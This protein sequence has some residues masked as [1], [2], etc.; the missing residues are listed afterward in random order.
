MVARYL[1]YFLN[2]LVSM[3]LLQPSHRSIVL[4]LYKRLLRSATLLKHDRATH[5]VQVSAGL[6]FR[7][8]RRVTRPDRIVQLLDD[9]VLSLRFLQLA[10]ERGPQRSVL[11]N[12][13]ET[14]WERLQLGRLQSKFS[15]KTGKLM[16]GM[17]DGYRRWIAA[18]QLFHGEVRFFAMLC[19]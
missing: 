18:L 5:Y 16:G 7:L 6:H 4:A 9:A 12:V 15:G 17:D 11:K 1:F 8:Q 14:E 3:A 2:S 10:A 13:V 19:D